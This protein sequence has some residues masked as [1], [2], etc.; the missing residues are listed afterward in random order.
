MTG[1]RPN[2]IVFLTDDQG[3]GDLGIYGNPDLDTPYIDRIGTCNAA[4]R[5]GEWKLYWPRIEEAM[6]KMKSDNLPFQK[7]CEVPH[8]LMNVEN[9]TDINLKSVQISSLP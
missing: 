1:K 5:D 8:F 4:M 2:I 9:P 7:N 6:Q 3:Y